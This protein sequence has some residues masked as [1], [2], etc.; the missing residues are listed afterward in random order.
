MNF[1]E[2][3][4]E[5]YEA[6]KCK[7]GYHWNSEEG[8]CVPMESSGDKYATKPIHDFDIIGNTG[9]DGD[10]YA[11][12]DKD[13]VTEMWNRSHRTPKQIRKDEE[14]ERQNRAQDARMRYGKSGRPPEEPLKKGEVRKWDKVKKQ[15]VSNK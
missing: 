9:I 5:L 2:F 15:W 14:Q 6:K 12:E 11:L 4:E 3:V 13:K 7:E 1:T 10:G 8:K